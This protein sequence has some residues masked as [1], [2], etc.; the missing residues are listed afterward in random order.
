MAKIHYFSN[1]IQMSLNHIERTII[2]ILCVD[3]QI[4]T[5]YDEDEPIETTKGHILAV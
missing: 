1:E 2:E 3:N 5:S 4:S